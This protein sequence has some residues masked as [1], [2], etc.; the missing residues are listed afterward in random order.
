MKNDTIID[1]PKVCTA[2]T[3]PVCGTNG[4][5]YPSKCDLEKAACNKG[6]ED[7]TVDYRGECKSL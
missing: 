7:M 5:T 3:P 2:D 4:K 1:C 6:N